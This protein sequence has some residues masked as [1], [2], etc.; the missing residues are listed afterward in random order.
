MFFIIW[1]ALDRLKSTPNYEKHQF[2]LLFNID[3]FK[4]VLFWP[5]GGGM[6]PLP[7]G[8]AGPES[9]KGECI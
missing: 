8:F 3:S 2:V 1:S 9:M 6:A 5:K 4:K 7:P